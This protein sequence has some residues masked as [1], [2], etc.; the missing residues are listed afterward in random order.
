MKLKSLALRG[1]RMRT[2]NLITLIVV[3]CACVLAAEAAAAAAPTPHSTVSPQI[4]A[5]IVF[6]ICVV[7]GIIAIIAGTGGGVLFTTLFMGFTSIHPDI[8]RATGLLAAVCGTRIGARRYL[9]RGI[10]NIR[11]V[12]LL[13]AC[14]T[15][16]AVIGAVFGLTI[17]RRFGDGGIAVIKLSLGVIVMAVGM[18][19]LLVKGTAYPETD[20]VDGFT[21]RLGLSMAYWEES[22]KRRIDYQV[23]RSLPATVI[24]C[25]VGF[26]SG[27]LG[28]GAGW[29]ITP[30]FNFVMLTP[31]KVAAASSAVIIS[32]GDT[33]A[34]FPYL[35]SNSIFP[36][37]AVPTITGLILG[38]EIGSRIAVK[39]KAKVIRYVLIT[40]M[41]G[42]GVK[43][44]ITGLR[45]L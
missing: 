7:I 22:L 13:G 25:F 4:F 19:Y 41:L 28:L 43:L 34:V 16:F 26:I 39:V 33:A 21:R 6:L 23:T 29:A 10:A 14:Y 35:M 44:I 5:L 45:L 17:T 18:M 9:R 27:T 8:V 42:T 2:K 40:I 36:V 31:L 38:A 15:T 1:D 11:L 32:L 37:Y 24:V 3:A 12:L 30:L 20:W